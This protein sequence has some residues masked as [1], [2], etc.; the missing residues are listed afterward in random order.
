[1]KK[2]LL[3]F[4]L[5]FTGCAGSVDDPDGQGNGLGGGFQIA[6]AKLTV[7]GFEPQVILEGRRAFVHFTFTNQAFNVSTNPSAGAVTG[8]IGATITPVGSP[9]Y[10]AQF[11]WRV[12]SLNRGSSTS[13]VVAF[14]APVASRANDIKLFF[15][16]ATTKAHVIEV[17]K[18]FDVGR[19]FTFGLGSVFADQIR[20]GSQDSLWGAVA[21]HNPNGPDPQP[22]TGDLG[23]VSTGHLGGS[24][25]GIGAIDAIPDLDTVLLGSILL[26]AGQ[27]INT[28]QDLEQLRN[29]A[30]AVMTG[31]DL[32]FGAT[33]KYAGTCDG[34]LDYE[35]VT[36]G[37]RQ[38][39]DLTG[40]PSST[41]F[42]DDATIRG[43]GSLPPAGFEND[44]YPIH[45]NASR[46]RMSVL[47]AARNRKFDREIV[48]QPPVASLNAGKSLTFTVEN[49]T[50]VDWTVDGGAINGQIDVQS[51]KYTMPSNIGPNT[52]VTIH[53][54]TP[55][56]KHSGVAYVSLNPVV[57]K[58]VIVG[59]GFTFVH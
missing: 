1:M 30:I 35:P 26:N 40:G 29:L 16:D 14:D 38:L 54:T 42:A 6:T 32:Q 12:D 13:G 58:P 57:P 15:E 20:S 21:A 17:H 43:A 45:C 10:E 27:F 53:A 22:D 24:F 2:Q 28:P 5:L 48:V 44:D 11:S 25:E 49:G 19:R 3:A 34:I 31:G 36:I 47:V 55:D 9:A 18:A 41:A 59:G 50:R 37:A 23:L 39:F 52:M 33:S 8:R 56:K 4:A 51:G 46:Y 7:D